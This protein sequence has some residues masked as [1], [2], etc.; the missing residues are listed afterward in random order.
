MGETFKGTYGFRSGN[1][2]LASKAVHG[3]GQVVRRVAV[4]RVFRM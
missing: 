1:Y 3:T 2:R 4:Q